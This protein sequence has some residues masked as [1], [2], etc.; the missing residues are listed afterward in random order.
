MGRGSL[1]FFTVM[2]FDKL[3]ELSDS[4][5]S[6]KEK[7]LTTIMGHEYY[8]AVVNV[9]FHFDLEENGGSYVDYTH[10]NLTGFAKNDDGTFWK[11]QRY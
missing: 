10:V 3:K 4:E 11:D 5:M 8:E 2:S 6:V 7:E 1:E 9:I